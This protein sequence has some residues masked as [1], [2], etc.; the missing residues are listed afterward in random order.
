[1][2]FVRRSTQPARVPEAFTR[3]PAFGALKPEAK[4]DIAEIIRL[5]SKR[6]DGADF[7]EKVKAVL[8]TPYVPASVEDGSRAEVAQAVAAAA[9]A[10]GDA[11]AEER[12]SADPARRWTTLTPKGG[13]ATVLREQG[14]KVP[15]IDV[16]RSDPNNI[17]A[18]VRVHLSGALAGDVA[19]L[20]DAI[21]KH[22]N[23]PGFTVDLQLVDQPGPDV[24]EVNT[25][26]TKW[27]EADNWV[28]NANTL[29]HE[30]MHLLG[31]DD[32]YDY[33]SHATN[34]AMTMEERLHWLKVEA[35][36]APAPA[37]AWQGIMTDQNNPV[38]DRQ[39]RA[40]AQLPVQRTDD[41][42]AQ[43]QIQRGRLARVVP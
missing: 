24:Y 11:G 15:H 42:R 13:R 37:D 17:V 12:I 36:R 31:L 30:L 21:E 39:V 33:R 35:G 32:E 10:G 7:L 19:K 40:V 27:A 6:S 28:G 1:M 22:V 34:A 25:D 3:E 9:A 29:G 41:A 18:R 26:P 38:L 16:D 23:R 20:E 8:E 5:A 14:K 4:A 43:A 2:P